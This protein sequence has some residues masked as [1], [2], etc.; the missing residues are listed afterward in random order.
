MSGFTPEQ[1]EEFQVLA[2][3]IAMRYK[4]RASWVDV[5]EFKQIA[6]LAFADAKPRWDPRVGVP[7]WKFLERAA[8]FACAKEMY[9]SRSPLHAGNGSVKKLAAFKR[10]PLDAAP[11]PASLDERQ[12][13]EAT[14][15]VERSERI[16]KSVRQVIRYVDTVVEKPHGHAMVRV[17]IARAVLLEGQKPEAVAKRVGLPVEDVKRACKRARKEVRTSRRLYKLSR[18][19]L[20]L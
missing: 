5:E 13:A 9:R 1:V 12:L 7:L 3:K 4:K 16:R 19:K 11:E 15:A 6:W 2:S 14:Y 8:T 17:N 20:P 10:A 18:D